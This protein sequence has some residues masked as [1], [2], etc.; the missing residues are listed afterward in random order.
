LLDAATHFFKSK[1][2]SLAFAKM[3]GIRKILR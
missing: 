1:K 2:L 3:A